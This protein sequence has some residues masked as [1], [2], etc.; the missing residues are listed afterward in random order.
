MDEVTRGLVGLKIRR[1]RTIG[2]NLLG[3]CLVA[4]FLIIR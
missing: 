2:I 1:T 3:Q 4:V